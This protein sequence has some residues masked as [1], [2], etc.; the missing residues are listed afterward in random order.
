MLRSGRH[1]V[2]QSTVNASQAWFDPKERSIGIYMNTKDIGNIGEHIAILEL[3]KL[4]I[5]VSRPLGDNSRYDLIIDL[6]GFLYKTQIKTTTSDGIIA[7]FMLSSSQAHRGKT[8]EYYS[9]KDVDIFLCVDI[10]TNKVFL[11][12]NDRKSIIIRYE[13]SQSRYDCSNYPEQFLLENC[14]TKL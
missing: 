7:Q 14:I 12:N 8:R 2:R 9:N 11:V 4:G 1:G 13:K 6:N 3:L 5:T 10:T